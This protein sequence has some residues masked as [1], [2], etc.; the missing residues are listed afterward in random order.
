MASVRQSLTGL[1]DGWNI[2][3]RMPGDQNS[4]RWQAQANI[5]QLLNLNNANLAG[6]HLV[7]WAAL[8]IDT[9]TNHALGAYAA[10]FAQELSDH[11]QAAGRQWCEILRYRANRPYDEEL[12][13][14]IAAANWVQRNYRRLWS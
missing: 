13:E 4:P 7:G 12:S 9:R 3:T 8:L 5:A 10:A 2:N 14:V 1:P 11:A 6:H